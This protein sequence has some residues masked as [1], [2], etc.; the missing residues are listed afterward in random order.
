M[1]MK[2][3]M[4]RLTHWDLAKLHPMTYEIFKLSFLNENCHV[5]K[6]CSHGTKQQQPTFGSGNGL[7]PTWRQAII[8]INKAQV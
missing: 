8:W 2:K 7:P 3:E 4:I 6:L 5:I 1:V